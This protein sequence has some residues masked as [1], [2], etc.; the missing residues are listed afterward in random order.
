MYVHVCHVNTTVCMYVHVC[1]M[2]ALL[3]VCMYMYVIC[4]FYCVYVCTSMSCVCSTVCMYVHVCH[5]SVLCVGFDML[6]T[7]I[8]NMSADSRTSGNFE[9]S[10]IYHLVK[11]E[12]EDPAD[13]Q[14]G[15]K[16]VSEVFLTRLL[17]TKVSTCIDIHILHIWEE[18]RNSHIYMQSTHTHA[19]IH[20][21]TPTHHTHSTE[22]PTK[23]RG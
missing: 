13:G 11:P 14:R 8:A 4:L 22:N 7:I 23:V 17:S 9:L 1:H 18:H 5:V 19:R 6:G 3:C 12:P 21:R 10:H 15:Q 20:S 16:I 2:S